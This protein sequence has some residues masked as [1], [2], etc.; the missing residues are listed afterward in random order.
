MSPA[1]EM[2]LIPILFQSIKVDT[3]HIFNIDTHDNYIVELIM[4]RKLRGRV[5]LQ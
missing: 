1:I 5:R 3:N 2:F 4:I